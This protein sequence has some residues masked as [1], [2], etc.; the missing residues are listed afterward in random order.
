VTI[1]VLVADDQRMIRDGLVLLIELLP[2]I[3]LAG[4]ADDGIR[5]IHLATEL[6]P[7]II[8]MDL[9]MPRMDGIEATRHICAAHPQI[10]IIALTTY[11]DDD[12]ILGVL[13]AG[14]RGY[15]TK[16]ASA[17]QIADA[18]TTVASGD[19]LLEPS[20]QARLLDHV[21]R[22][23]PPTGEAGEP[24]DDL[25]NREVEVLQLISQGLSNAEIA[26]RLVV[27]AAT[28]KTHINHIFAKTGVRDRAQAVT[29]AYR[30]GLAAP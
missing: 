2:D 6:Q 10:G 30:Q 12:S 8:L 26:T 27:T 7:D 15:L 29:Y 22:I 5:A 3:E 21:N 19:A 13:Q 14:A 4:T 28:V 18:I 16:D 24:P 20:V 11:A 17:E 25:T 1:R 23:P 9:D